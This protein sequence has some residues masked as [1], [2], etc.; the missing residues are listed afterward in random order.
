MNVVAT[1]PEFRR[2]AIRIWLLLIV[3]HVFAMVMVGGATRLTGSGLSIVE[4]K[5]I[6]GTLPPLSVK[7][8]EAEFEKYKAIPQYHIGHLDRVARIEAAVSKHPGLFVTGNAF[9]GVAMNDVTE[10]AELI[11]GKVV[12]YLAT[13]S[14]PSGRGSA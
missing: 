2:R 11:A 13:T 8:W 4:W 6:T 14:S 9:H 1:E 12:A 3:V 10:Q 5:P 7:A